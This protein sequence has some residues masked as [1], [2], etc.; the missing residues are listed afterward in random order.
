[1]NWRTF[2]LTVLA[3]G[4]PALS[5]AAS[6]TDLAKQAK[7]IFTTY[8]YR[9]HGQNGAAEGGFNAVVDLPTLGG[10][11][12]PGDLAKS[13]AYKRM[14]SETMPPEGEQ[15]RPKADENRHH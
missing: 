14:A 12:R 4:I 15:P 13:R 1:M 2:M 5:Q 6:N 8:C 3:A 9:C 7:Q 11:V 10:K